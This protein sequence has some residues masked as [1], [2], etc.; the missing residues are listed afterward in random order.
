MTIEQ[1]R[2]QL[3]GLRLQRRMADARDLIRAQPGFESSPA[4]Q[5]LHHDHEDFWWQPM[6]GRRMT[7]RRRDEGDAAFVRACWADAGFMH[8]FNRVARPLPADDEALRG[9]LARERAAIFGESKALHWTIDTRGG[10]AGFVSATDYTPGHRRCEFLIGVLN[11]PASPVPVE[12]AREAIAFL[13]DRAGVER[14]TAYIYA[15]NG[16]A[17]R[18]AVKFGFEREGVLRGY[19]R[20]PDGSRSDLVVAGMLLG[21]RRAP[22]TPR[23]ARRA[24][25][26]MG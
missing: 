21:R 20:E 23:A 19:L 3:R 16:Y 5:Q 12:A 4:L 15:D 7:L 24:A 22:G 18:L 10:P 26:Q 1:L 17:T 13:R 11:R 6:P 25:R 14:L 9:I 8:K 2:E